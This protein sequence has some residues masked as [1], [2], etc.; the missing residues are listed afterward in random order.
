MGSLSRLNEIILKLHSRAHSGPFP[1]TSRNLSRGN[2]GGPHPEVE[3]SSLSQHTQVLSP[4]ETSYIIR[5][6]EGQFP[7]CSTGTSPGK[8]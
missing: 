6:V 4:E 1:E 8:Q 5:G 7:L 2:P 3:N